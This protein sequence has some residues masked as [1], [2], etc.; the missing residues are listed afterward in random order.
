[1]PAGLQPNQHL[2]PNPP[3]AYDG[4]RRRP[5]PEPPYCA[6]F[7]CPID[8]PVGRPDARGS[9]YFTAIW[10]AQLRIQRTLEVS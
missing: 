6:A 5:A 1:M 9:V 3:G 4:R 7:I 8:V 2:K 10:F